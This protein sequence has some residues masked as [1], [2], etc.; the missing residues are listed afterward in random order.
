MLTVAHKPLCFTK[1]ACALLNYYL[2]TGRHR[3]GAGSLVLSVAFATSEHGA[4]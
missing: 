4:A 2:M 1:A 3:I